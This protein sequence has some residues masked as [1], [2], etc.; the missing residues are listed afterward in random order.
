MTSCGY[1]VYYNHIDPPTVEVLSVAEFK[2]F[3]EAYYDVDLNKIVIKEGCY[4]RDLLAHELVHSLQPDSLFAGD[5]HLDYYEKISE[6]QAY[7]V[8]TLLDVKYKS[9]CGAIVF[10]SLMANLTK[11]IVRNLERNCKQTTFEMMHN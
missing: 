6:I 8:S 9:R 4:S 7:V 1:D 11:K 2:G 10:K 5:E 3:G